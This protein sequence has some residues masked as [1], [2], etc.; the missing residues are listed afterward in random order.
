V[1]KNILLLILAFSAAVLALAKENERK[2]KDAENV[3]INGRLMIEKGNFAINSG[4]LIYYVIGLN[5]VAG[6]IDGLKEGAQVTFNGVALT[7]K[8]SERTKLLRV[9][10][11]TFNGKDYEFENNIKMKHIF[12]HRPK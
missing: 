12:R 7:N 6:F 11:L 2:W 10:K 3:T 1:K 4:G 9:S 8:L 5:S